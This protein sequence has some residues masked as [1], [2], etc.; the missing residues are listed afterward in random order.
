MKKILALFLLCLSSLMV[1][2]ATA[3]TDFDDKYA[4]D[5]LKPGT[6]APDFQLATPDGK[7]VKF[8]DFSKGKYVVVDFW[9]SWCPDCRKDA[10]EIIRLYNHF[11]SK[12]VEFIG[13]SFDT[14]KEK[15]T[16]CIEKLGI[17]YEQVS[18]MKRM[19][20]SK[21]AAAYGI[22]WIPSVYV[23][24][25]AGRVI[26]QTVTTEKLR[27][28][29][30]LLDKSKVYIPR[31]KREAE[32][33]F[34]GGDDAMMLFLSR[35]IK[36]PR[37]AS[38]YGLEGQTLLKFLVNTDG[39]ISNVR[40]I[41]NKITKEDRLPFRTLPEEEKRAMRK[42]VLASFAEEGIRVVESMPRWKAGVRYGMQMKTEYELPINYKI[43][44]KNDN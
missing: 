29:L 40:V 24:N 33:T 31:S 1:M 35:N 39:S 11:H 6:P 16:N 14:D 21:V 44:Y 8:S 38:N 26:L 15:W 7:M 5:L 25:T 34:P 42:K 18:E 19:K 3:Q 23:L 2:E 28:R 4:V 12:G 32:P 36:Y 17:P 22:K 13:V 30:Q 37:L 27:K 43:Q 10:P 20:D 41:D 9:A